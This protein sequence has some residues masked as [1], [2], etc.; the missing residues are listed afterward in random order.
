MLSDID[1]GRAR[2]AHT[3]VETEKAQRES[4][5]LADQERR[6]AGR[7]DQVD[8]GGAAMAGTDVGEFR[9]FRDYKRTGVKPQVMMGDVGAMDRGFDEQDAPLKPF[10]RYD[11]SN[12]SKTERMARSLAATV[13]GN[14]NKEVNPH[15]I[16]QA[17]GDLQRQGVIDESVAAARRG[18]L[19]GVRMHQA[20]IG[21]NVAY[22]PSDRP[23]NEMTTFTKNLT[24]AGIEPASPLGQKFMRAYLDK[25][26]SHAPGTTINMPSASHYGTDPKSGQPGMFQIGRDGSVNF[27]PINPAP[28]TDP[29]KSIIADAFRNRQPGASN[30]AGR[31][32]AEAPRDPRQRTANTVYLTPRGPLRWT[33]TGWVPATAN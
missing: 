7:D 22:A 24:A 27:T 16:T 6:L 3:N 1:L 14:L 4:N 18:D 13:L 12:P 21:G 8:L 31:A 26:S 32:P 28:S 17:S 33:G 15:T 11:W 19:D 2:L 9:A 23:Q 25:V 29:V 5:I 10:D 20:S 30:A